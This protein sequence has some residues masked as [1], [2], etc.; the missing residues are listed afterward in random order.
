MRTPPYKTPLKMDDFFDY[1]FDNDL[2]AKHDKQFVSKALK[3]TFYG[4]HYSKTNFAFNFFTPVTAPI[5][6]A[7]VSVASMGIA[8]ALVFKS[9]A[10]L[11]ITPKE[12]KTRSGNAVKSL[13]ACGSLFLI[14]LATALL[15]A[16]SPLIALASLA[17][18]SVASLAEKCAPAPAPAM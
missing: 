18:S 15:T 7:A 3:Q 9:I 10:D 6:L 1:I 2:S 11:C 14:A 4:A 5:A 8:V 13:K 17:G 12:G 16:F